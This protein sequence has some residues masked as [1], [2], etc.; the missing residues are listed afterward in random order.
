MLLVTSELQYQ[1]KRVLGKLKFT[2]V[3]VK[4][5][6][7]RLDFDNQKS[8]LSNQLEYE[9]S[10]DTHQNVM[11]WREMIKNDEANIEN[12]KKEEKKAIKVR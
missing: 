10:L 7:Y 5:F 1:W 2:E 8:R 12:H 4:N 11:K 9:N 6:H 3:L